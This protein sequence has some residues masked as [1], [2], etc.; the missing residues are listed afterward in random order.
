MTIYYCLV[1]NKH[2]PLAEHSNGGDKKMN[3]IAQKLLKKLNFEEDS[4]ES[5]DC[6]GKTYSYR[7][8]GEIVYV[9]VTNEAFGKNSAALFLKH[10]NQLFDDQF[11]IRGKMTKLKLDMNRDFAPTLKKQMELFSSEAGSE[12]LEALKK[13]LNSVKDSVQINIG[14]VLERGDKIE[15]LVDKSEQLNMALGTVG[16]RVISRDDT[17]GNMEVLNMKAL[18]ERAAAK[19][20]KKFVKAKEAEENVDLM[21]TEE[22]KTQLAQV[23]EC[24]EGNKKEK[25]ETEE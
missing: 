16:H 1:A 19:I 11:G 13:D 21:M 3:E 7:V 18:D 4:L 17:S 15:L 20:L 8:E 24:L 10:I 14:K 6:D 22:V 9:C 23:L 5:V 2:C 25:V 12:K